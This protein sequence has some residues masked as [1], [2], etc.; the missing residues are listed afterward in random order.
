MLDCAPRADIRDDE[1]AGERI[2]TACSTCW[3]IA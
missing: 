3:A 2:E 1:C